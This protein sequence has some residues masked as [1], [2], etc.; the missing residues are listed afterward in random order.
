MFSYP[1]SVHAVEDALYVGGAA[2]QHALVL[3]CFAGS[4]TTGHAAINL[5]R[6]DGGHRRFVLAE[7]ETYFDSVL[8]PRIAK[9]MYSPEWDAARPVNYPKPTLEGMWPEWVSRTPRLVKVLRLEGYEDS[10]HNLVTEETLTVEAPRAQA[11]QQT[12]G[13][14]AYRLHY[15]AR[16]PLES[17]DALL[18]VDRLAHPF[19]YT[20]EILT[21]EGPQTSPVDL[22][23]TFNL[24]YGLRVKRLQVWH[25]PADGNRE[26]R[27]V[28]GRRGEEETLVIWR[29]MAGLDPA[30]ERTFLGGRVGEYD[31]VLINGDSAV[32][33]IESLDPLFTRLME[34]DAP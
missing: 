10:L 25:N 26:Y 7:M 14:E 8:L 31:R 16:L 24:L 13:P 1:K 15:L 32:P 27:V 20:L 23:E 34:A 2:K 22:V 17:S 18:D 9:V 4:G 21:D 29:D 12:I 28:T 33:G 6:R 19:A 3:D 5:N 30:V 11:Y